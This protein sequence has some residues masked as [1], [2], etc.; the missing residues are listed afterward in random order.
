M[1]HR[2]PP[3]S[4]GMLPL[5]G[6]FCDDLIFLFMSTASAMLN[7]GRCKFLFII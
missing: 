2:A 7:A 5:A 3:E 4:G 6:A 1:Q